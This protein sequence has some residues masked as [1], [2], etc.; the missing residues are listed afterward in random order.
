MKSTATINDV[1]LS[2]ARLDWTGTSQDQAE[3]AARLVAWLGP[4]TRPAAINANRIDE[5]VLWLRSS[6]PSG[7][8]LSNAT[9]NRYLSALRVMLLRAQRMGA[10][11]TLPLFP[12]RRQLKEA[13]PR[14]LVLQPSWIEALEQ[15]IDP[16]HLQLL[17]FLRWQG[18]RI[19]EA[20]DLGWDRVSPS[21]VQFIKTKGRKARRLP[22][23]PAA[24]EAMALSRHQGN[25]R[26]FPFK[27][28]AMRDRYHRAVGQ[29]CEQ[30][31]LSQQTRD[32]W[33]IHT[34]RHT[35]LTELA[36]LGWSAPALQ[37]FAGHSSLAV[38]QRYVHQSSVNLDALVQGSTVSA[39]RSALAE[40]DTGT[41]NTP[42][43]AYL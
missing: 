8:G 24:A 3:N 2:S 4:R 5:L 26:P 32:Q 27:Y 35:R 41:A 42:V 7:R 34:L 36:Q 19:T 28:Q 14:E 39:M 40:S 23:F 22:L 11:D 38:T 16:R 10:L 18:C 12:E 37:Q 43:V 21:H 9:I 15:A 25:S 13:E 30:L 17:V 6:G 31:H 1:F 29:V 33:T 20:L